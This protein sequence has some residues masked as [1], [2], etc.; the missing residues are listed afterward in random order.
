MNDESLGLR[1]WLMYFIISFNQLNINTCLNQA[2]IRA[3]IEL[4]A[5]LNWFQLILGL[6]SYLIAPEFSLV[7]S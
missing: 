7:W 6:S 4:D 3:W 5:C 1:L 2:I